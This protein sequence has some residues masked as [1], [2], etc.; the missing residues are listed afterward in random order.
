MTLLD[1][2]SRASSVS[3]FKQEDLAGRRQA[4]LPDRSL[5]VT[6][7]LEMVRMDTVLELMILEKVNFELWRKIWL[8]L[9]TE[10]LTQKYP[11]WN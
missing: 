3:C 5:M 6:C 8:L 7:T 11:P 1:F 9:A 2:I 4:R 10:K